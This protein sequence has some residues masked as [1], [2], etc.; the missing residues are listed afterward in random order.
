MGSVPLLSVIV[1]A[2][3]RRRYL[4]GAVRS[5]IK[6]EIPRGLYEVIVVKNFRDDDIDRALDE[7][8][9]TNLHSGSTGVGAKVAE[10]LGV[11]RGDVIALL[12]D[13]DEFLPGKL[14]AVLRAFSSRPRLGLYRNA[15]L[16]VDESGRP[17][18]RDGAR[19]AM[20]ADCSERG[21]LRHMAARGLL[22]NSSSMAVRREVLDARDSVLRALE[23]A[24]DSYYPLRALMNG[25]RVLM[26]PRPLTA[27][28]IH[29]AQTYGGTG[30]LEDFR[31][32][33]ARNA[34][35]YL[36]DAWLILRA[37]RGSPCEGLARYLYVF[38][39]AGS[40]K[41]AGGLGMG[42]EL[43]GSIGVSPRDLVAYLNVELLRPEPFRLAKL[44]LDLGSF[45]LPGA[46]MGSLQRVPYALRLKNLSARRPRSA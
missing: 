13:D 25:Y 35:R 26:D 22:F 16:T 30:S 46:I 29:G 24:V 37:A 23:L 2:H 45:A 7:W 17:I 34:L 33:G 39:A 27:Y 4:L 20:E 8:G 43:R 6:Q 36:G 11:A 40:M 1:T 21:P 5:V 3:D 42:R 32:R 12:D 31:R 38:H 10:A 44:A 18:G 9:I 15:L 14:E 19:E 41:A 28:R